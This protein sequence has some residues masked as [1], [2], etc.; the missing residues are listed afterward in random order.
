MSDVERETKAG[1]L[2]ALDSQGLET[3]VRKVA[4]A[5]GDARAGH[6][7]AVDGGHQAAEQGVLEGTRPMEAVLDICVP[8]P[9]CGTTPPRDLGTIYVYQIPETTGLFA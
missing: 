7:Q 4:V 1:F 2:K 9:G 5:D 8:F 6:Q 3:E